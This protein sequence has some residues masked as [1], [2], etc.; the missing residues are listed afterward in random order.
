MHAQ[1]INLF[2]LA[3]GFLLLLIPIIIL[4]RYRTG[5]LKP[6]IISVI[7][8][9]LQLFMVG[10]YLKYLFE[11]NNHWVNIGWLL[12]MTGVCSIDLINRIKMPL[13][14]LF[15][16][17]YISTFVSLAFVVIYFLKVVLAI[18]FMF[19]SRYFIPICG[20]LLGN[21]LS[22]N[23]IGLSAFYGGILRE[24]QMYYYLLGNGATQTEA[25]TPFIKDA[26]IKAF[27]P[28]IA[29]MA[30]MGLI[31]L[32]G[33]MIGQIIGGSSPDIAIRYQIMILIIT[34]SSSILALL[35]SLLWSVRYT[36]DKYGR[37]INY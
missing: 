25:I 32:P 37:F 8:M 17:V 18:E 3:I 6:M 12:L 27:N 5:L 22:T 34:F 13:K 14:V 11:W 29:N 20:I 35:T 15:V 10:F 4:Y 23:V 28:T 9:T 26:L 1:D 36:F 21:I 2:H 24:K 19:E 7:R 33:T 30:V 31:A 16:S